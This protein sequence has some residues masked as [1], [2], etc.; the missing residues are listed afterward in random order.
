M[1]LAIRPFEDEAL[2]EIPTITSGVLAAVQ[3]AAMAR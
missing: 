1:A 2:K 3:S